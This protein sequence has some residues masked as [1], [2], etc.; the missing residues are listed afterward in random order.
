LK[1]VAG[2]SNGIED[3]T[4]GAW[5][6]VSSVEWDDNRVGV[7][8]VAKDVMAAFHPVKPPSLAF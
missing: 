7:L 8:G 1:F 6:K 4:Q 5:F 3:A 2:Y